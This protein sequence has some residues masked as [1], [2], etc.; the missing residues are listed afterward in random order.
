M[1]LNGLEQMYYDV[2]TKKTGQSRDYKAKKFIENKCIKI[3]N[4]DMFKCTPIKGY[5][6]TTYTITQYQ[7]KWAC[8]CQ[9]H[10]QTGKVC[11]HI[12]AVSLFMQG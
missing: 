7:G 8:N 10:Q 3:V 2:A 12:K 5:N 11:S 9:F 6:K 1:S 4:R